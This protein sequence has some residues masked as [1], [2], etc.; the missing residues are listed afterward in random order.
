MSGKPSTILVDWAWEF[1]TPGAGHEKIRSQFFQS[2]R[3]LYTRTI[4]CSRKT[5]GRIKL[6]GGHKPSTTVHDKPLALALRDHQV[7]A[8]YSIL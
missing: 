3:H 4:G 6:M 5:F 7:P 1:F 8:A 2:V